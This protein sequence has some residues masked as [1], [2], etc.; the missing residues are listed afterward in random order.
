MPRDKAAERNEHRRKRRAQLRNENQERYD[1]KARIEA[2]ELACISQQ[3]EKAAEQAKAALQEVH[4]R[5]RSTDFRAWYKATTGDDI[6]NFLM[7]ILISSDDFANLRTGMSQLAWTQHR[8]E[9]LV[10]RNP[11]TNPE[12]KARWASELANCGARERRLI[13]VR[14][15]TQRW[16][17]QDAV[18]AIY[19]ERDRIAEETGVPHDVDHI[20][21]IVSHVVCGLH[22]HFNM[23]VVPASENRS[24]SNRFPDGHFFVD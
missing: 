12:A 10:Q 18:I 24:K 22:V 3:Y 23:R 20:Y 19:K 1:I 5:I 9:Y 8:I 6:D 17:D 7:E 13:L 21:P 2:S 4:A 16:S 14:L 15:A 11:W